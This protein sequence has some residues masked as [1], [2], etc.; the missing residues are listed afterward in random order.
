M[1]AVVAFTL[2]TPDPSLQQWC[3]DHH[4]PLHIAG[5]D[6]YDATRPP[7]WSRIKAMQAYLSKYPSIVYMDA[8]LNYQPNLETLAEH[9]PAD[10][11]ILVVK[12]PFGVLRL[13]VCVLRNTPWTEC[14]L[15][16]IY[17]QDQWMHHD[18]TSSQAFFDLYLNVPEVRQKTEIVEAKTLSINLTYPHLE[19][20]NVIP[21]PPPSLETKSS[22]GK[23][24]EG[25]TSDFPTGT[26]W[27][28]MEGPREI[29]TIEFLA[30]GQVKASWGLATWSALPERRV[31]IVIGPYVDTLTFTNTG[32]QV[33]RPD[34]YTA[35]GIRLGPQKADA[36]LIAMQTLPQETALKVSL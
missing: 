13:D 9:L 34:G 32:F 2:G 1:T 10:K 22:P 27:K 5:L 26:S 11:D 19:V 16:N 3:I 21:Q 14:L 4:Y 6:V 28:W 29:G 8:N 18:L 25:V 24:I 30:G 15:D 36:V 33:T 7:M 31:K 17:Q 20:K 23:S 35:S 12:D